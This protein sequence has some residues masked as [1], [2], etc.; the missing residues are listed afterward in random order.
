MDALSNLAFTTSG[1]LI[2]LVDSQLISLR[3][4]FLYQASSHT[5]STHLQRRYWCTSETAGNSLASCALT[6]NTVRLAA[7][8]YHP[9]APANPQY[10]PHALSIPSRF[11]RPLNV[12]NS[13]PRNYSNPRTALPPSHKLLRPDRT[14]SLS[15]PR[16]E[17]RAA[18]RSGT[19]SILSPF[20]LPSPSAPARRADSTTNRLELITG[21]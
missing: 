13:Q 4:E 7:L 11:R 2:D 5:C 14:W 20:T 17:R 12:P 6:I 1:A 10:L 9:T 21:P 3:Y 19:S 8:L 15:D 18:R 16:R